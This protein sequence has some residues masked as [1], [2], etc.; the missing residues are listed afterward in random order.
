MSI[1][2]TVVTLKGS[3]IS[4]QQNKTKQ[5]TS[6]FFFFLL[7]SLC[8]LGYLHLEEEQLFEQLTQLFDW[9]LIGS[10]KSE[11]PKHIQA[12]SIALQGTEKKI[13]Y[14]KKTSP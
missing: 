4:Q 5:N 6:L 9:L 13:L 14:R 8:F 7:K 12:D 10:N 3:S 1:F 2:C 11:S